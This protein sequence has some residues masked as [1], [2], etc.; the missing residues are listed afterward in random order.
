VYRFQVTDFYTNESNLRTILD[1]CWIVY[2]VIHMHTLKHAINISLLL[3][4]R[5][6]CASILSTH[7]M[8]E[9]PK[10]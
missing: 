9:I 5:E 8:I 3:G 1:I 6:G 4:Y 7:W 10:D 2:T